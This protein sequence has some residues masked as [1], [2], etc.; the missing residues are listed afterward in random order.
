MLKYSQLILLFLFSGTLFSQEITATQKI[1]ASALPGTDFVVETTINKGSSTGFMKFFQELPAGFTAVDIESK[2]GSFTFAD[3]GAKVVWIAPPQD[4]V[5]TIS[6]R[7]TVAG[8]ISGVQSMPGKISY[9]NN[10]ERQTFDFPAASI[11]IGTAGSPVK[12]EIPSTNPV[13]S[14]TPAKTE[15]VK[16]E[17]VKTTPPPAGNGAA[18]SAKTTPPPAQ[19]KK[20]PSQPTTFNKIPTSALPATSAGRMYKVQIGAFSQKP[21]IDGVP[22]VSTFV[23]DNG[24]T[25]YFSGNFATYEDAVKRK[26][27]MTDKGFQGAFIVAFENGKPVK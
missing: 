23:L 14:T 9:I 6:Y 4:P 11:T 13:V 5:F 22:E 24:I 19:E 10:N 1:P 8:G 21:K 20:E 26:K 12:K 16:T 18:A 27:E 3:G 17:P 2:G 25:K 7:V 15:P